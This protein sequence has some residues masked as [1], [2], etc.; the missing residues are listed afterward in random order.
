MFEK[1]KKI[2][3]KD[4]DYSKINRSE[5]YSKAD[6]GPKNLTNTEEFDN[7][8]NW[9]DLTDGWQKASP[10]QAKMLDDLIKMLDDKHK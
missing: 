6:V 4:A 2:F 8:E 5:N 10:E 1:L 9:V 3:K 7:D